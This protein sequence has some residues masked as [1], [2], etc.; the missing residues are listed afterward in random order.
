MRRIGIEP[1]FL[2]LMQAARASLHEIAGLDNCLA[3]AGAA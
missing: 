2:L 3:D 1:E